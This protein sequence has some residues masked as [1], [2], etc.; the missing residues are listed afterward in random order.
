MIEIRIASII[1]ALAKAF[2]KIKDQVKSQ[3]KSLGDLGFVVKASL[4]T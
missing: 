3:M 1:I 2:G 4:S